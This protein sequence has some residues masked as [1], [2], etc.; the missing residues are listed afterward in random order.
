MVEISHLKESNDPTGDATF[1]LWR[2]H[3]AMSLAQTLDIVTACVPFLKP[4]VDGLESGMIRN[5]DLLRRTTSKATRRGE[6]RDTMGQNPAERRS[7]RFLQ[8]RWR[9]QTR[10]GSWSGSS[11]LAM[12][13]ERHAHAMGP[14][15]SHGTSNSVVTNGTRGTSVEERGSLEIEWGGFASEAGQGDISTGS[16]Q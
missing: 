2:V 3:I 12:N 9:E 1:D 15:R 10:R 13:H 5:D 7:G 14:V 8:G 11:R 6:H 16:R 4:F